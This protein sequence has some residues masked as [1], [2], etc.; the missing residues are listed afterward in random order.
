MWVLAY[1]NYIEDGSGCS[2]ILS[3]FFYEGG[4]NTLQVEMFP[5]GVVF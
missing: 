4:N 2:K 3:T 5:D 1:G